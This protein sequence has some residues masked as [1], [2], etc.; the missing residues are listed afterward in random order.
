MPDFS[1]R[2]QKRANEFLETGEEFVFA[3][4]AQPRG[5][6]SRGMNDG[7]IRTGLRGARDVKQ[8]LD[9]KRRDRGDE[10]ASRVPVAN[11]YLTLTSERLLWLRQTKLGMA[12][13]EILAAYALDEVAGASWT[14]G[15]GLGNQELLLTFG[16]E[17]EASVLIHNSQKPD[18]LR[19][20]LDRLLI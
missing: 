12:T 11:G 19:S 13:G 3:V 15:S 10:L 8:A 18:R 16:D 7:G 5:S 17:S 4:V 2:V 1:K 14:K 20:E 6:I 9:D